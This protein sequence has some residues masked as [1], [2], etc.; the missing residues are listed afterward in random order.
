LKPFLH[1]AAL[2]GDRLG[3]APCESERRQRWIGGTK[4]REQRRPC[5]VGVGHVM[6]AAVEVR[7]G[8]LSRGAHPQRS[9]LVMCAA[10]QITH[11]VC[12][13]EVVVVW[14]RRWRLVVLRARITTVV[15]YA[16]LVDVLDI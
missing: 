10:K 7:H 1:G 12:W 6:K 11:L 8:V 16:V 13:I 2:S 14:A 4:R 9:R 3:R 15:M 5:G